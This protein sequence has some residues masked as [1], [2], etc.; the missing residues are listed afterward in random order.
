MPPS[1]DTHVRHSTVPGLCPPPRYSRP[2]GG[3]GQA[4]E[5]PGVPG[6]GAVVS[7]RTRQRGPG[8]PGAVV[9]FRALVARQTAVLR[10]RGAG[11]GDAVVP[12]GAPVRRCALP[13]GAA[14]QT[15]WRERMRRKNEREKRKRV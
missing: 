3:A 13:W 15:W 8:A 12:G 4:V 6:D 2:T 11:P 9:T 10:R 1:S 5:E 7:L 14:K